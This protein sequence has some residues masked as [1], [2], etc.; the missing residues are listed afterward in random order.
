MVFKKLFID[1][2]DLLFYVVMKTLN[3]LNL[4]MNSD[5]T[6]LDNLVSDKVTLKKKETDLLYETSDYLINIEGNSEYSNAVNVKNMSYVLALLLRQLKPG[7]NNKIKKVLQ[8]NINNENPLNNGEFM[9]VSLFT[10][11]LSGKVRYED[12]I[13]IDYNL[14][15]LNKM[16]YNEV[17]SLQDDDIKKIFYAFTR[18]NND[19]YYDLYNSNELGQEL[20]R[21]MEKMMENIDSILY[22][23]KVE[24]A[25][26]VGEEIGFNKG[27]SIGFSKGQSIGLIKG[28]SIGFNNG[29]NE[30]IKNL[31]KNKMP[32]EDIIKFAQIS[33]EELDEIKKGMG[34]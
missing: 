21:R 34:K 20:L 31:I 14:E 28:Q 4:P 18:D 10:D 33:K 8:I 12:A 5:I 23:D 27:E 26:T 1:N 3:S 11:V 30:T 29:K 22:Y 32:E 6:V 19:K 15:Y 13:V 24:F 16:T 25:K 2:Y 9:G 7:E 17:A